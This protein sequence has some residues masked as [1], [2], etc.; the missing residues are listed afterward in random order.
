ML[1]KG[2]LVLAACALASP[3]LANAPSDPFVQD[4][5]VLR[6]DGLDLTTTQGQRDLDIR[7]NAAARAVCGDRLASVHLAVA[8][9]ARQCRTEV[10]ANIREEIETR[11]A[12]SDSKVQL[13]SNR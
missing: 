8:S 3:A 1:K 5:A 7:M 6:L 13:A 12:A 11:I 4:G 9:S 10:L 2:L